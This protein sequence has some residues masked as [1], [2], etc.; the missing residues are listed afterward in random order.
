MRA[1]TGEIGRISELRL[2]WYG[3][4]GQ[5]ISEYVLAITVTSV[6]CALLVLVLKGWSGAGAEGGSLA[7]APPHSISAGGGEST[8]LGDAVVH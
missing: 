7:P 6:V 2:G 8:W 1:T 4:R 3:E 5:G